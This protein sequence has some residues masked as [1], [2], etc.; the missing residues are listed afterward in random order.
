LRF[1]KVGTYTRFTVSFFPGRSTLENVG[2]A[3]ESMLKFS[4]GVNLAIHSMSYLASCDEPVTAAKIATDIG[5]SRDHLS[6]ILQRLSKLGF[7]R[8]QR[9]PKGGFMLAREPKEITVLE[10]V[11]AIE[12]AWTS[13]YCIM[14][15]EI[16]GDAC[17]LHDLTTE[18]H[19][20]VREKLAKATLD[21]LPVLGCAD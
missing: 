18:I 16:C 1:L 21:K 8:S 12:G 4:E 11:E 20:K 14:G 3:G 9:G 19:E 17:T 13:P 5:V 10:L 2:L 15:G 6:K 7:V